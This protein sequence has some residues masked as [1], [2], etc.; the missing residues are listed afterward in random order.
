LSAIV[1]VVVVAIGNGV[2]PPRRRHGDV[3]VH[4]QGHVTAM[5]AERHL[6]PGAGR[7]ID[8]EMNGRV[9]GGVDVCGGVLTDAN[10]ALTDPH[11]HLNVPEIT[12]DVKPFLLSPYVIGQTIIFS[13]CF[14]LSFFFF[15]FF[16]SPNLSGV[17]DWMFTI[18]WHMVWP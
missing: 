11:A 1:V 15:F 18:L 3:T 12:D 16:S 10:T 13:S 4:V 2:P 9:S 8:G 17:G 5:D 7:Q 14:F 6:V